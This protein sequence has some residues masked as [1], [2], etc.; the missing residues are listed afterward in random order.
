[1]LATPDPL[2][3]GQCLPAAFRSCTGSPYQRFSS[4]W[5]RIAPQ[6]CISGGANLRQSA[7]AL[8]CRP[9]T[10]RL[11]APGRRYE[12]LYAILVRCRSAAANQGMFATPVSFR[13]TQNPLGAVLLPQALIP[14]GH[15]PSPEGPFEHIGGLNVRRLTPVPDCRIL[16]RGTQCLG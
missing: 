14:V 1:M 10:F 13:L 2:W 6:P 3:L 11:T 12:P 9:V 4:L 15:S 5:L 7:N 16:P 8:L